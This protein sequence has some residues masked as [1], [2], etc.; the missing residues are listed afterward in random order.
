V[1]SVTV[2]LD[3]G[4]KIVTQHEYLPF[5]ETWTHEGDK[6]HNPKYNSQE[7]DKESGYYF[8]NARHYDPEISRFVTADTVIDGEESAI[9]WNRYAYCKNNPIIYKDPTGHVVPLAVGAAVAAVVL[10][11]REVGDG[12]GKDKSVGDTDQ[13]YARKLV[14]DVVA[15]VAGEKALGLA[16]KGIK[17]GATKVASAAKPILE[18]A[19]DTTA[20]KIANKVAGKVEGLFGKKGVTSAAEEATETGGKIYQTYTK[21]HPETGKVYSGRTSGHGAPEQNL[22]RRDASH[23]MNK[24]GYGPAVLDQSSANKAAIRGREQ[25]LIDA[26]GGAQSMDGTSGN[27]INSI[28]E[29]NPKRDSYLNE[30]LKVFK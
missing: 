26:H 6:K 2:V 9:G 14:T 20:G 25:Q 12:T 23:H 27:R 5:G 4:G 15:T 21:T 11:A 22:A 19:A 29:S 7:L 16:A 30:A 18:S 10:V 13:T 8:Y 17:A 1:D 24:E 28:S 3:D